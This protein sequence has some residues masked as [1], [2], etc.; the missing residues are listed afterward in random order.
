MASPRSAPSLLG[1]VPTVRSY[2]ETARWRRVSSSP[3]VVAATV[4]D[5]RVGKKYD[6]QVKAF[7]SLFTP[8]GTARCG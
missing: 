2:G 8:R 7:G 5:E 6:V 4:R 3:V 1:R